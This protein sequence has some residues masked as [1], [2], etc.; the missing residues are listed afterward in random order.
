MGRIQER[1]SH[2][3]YRSYKSICRVWTCFNP[4]PTTGWQGADGC[5]LGFFI[6]PIFNPSSSYMDHSRPVCSASHY[7]RGSASARRIQC[8][9]YTST[10]CSEIHL[11]RVRVMTARP[12]ATIPQNIVSTLPKSM[13]SKTYLSYADAD[14]PFTCKRRVDTGLGVLQSHHLDFYALDK[15]TGK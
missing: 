10:I 5:S 15:R 13:Y 6:G 12:R 4:N 1:N 8:V 11:S 2:S 9:P 14:F 3:H 7:S